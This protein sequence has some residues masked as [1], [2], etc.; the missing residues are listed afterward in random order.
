MSSTGRRP[1]RS[2]HRPQIGEKRNCIT[3]NEAMM[4]PIV[5]PLAPNRWL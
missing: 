5:K 4:R 1:I 3:E 2:D